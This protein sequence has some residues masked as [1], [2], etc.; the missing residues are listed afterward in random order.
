LLDGFG[1]VALDCLSIERSS[2]RHIGCSLS[3]KD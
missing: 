2:S 3:S 1:D